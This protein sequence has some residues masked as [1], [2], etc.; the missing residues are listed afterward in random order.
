MTGGWALGNDG[1]DF[2]L[3]QAKIEVPRLPSRALT[4]SHLLARLGGIEQSP[5]AVVVAPAGWGKTLLLSSWLRDQPPVGHVAW[6]SVDPSDADPARF[7]AYVLAALGKACDLSDDHPLAQLRRPLRA[8]VADAD[9]FLAHL[10]NGLESLDVGVT[11]VLDD[12]HLAASADVTRELAFLV[13]HRPHSLNLVLAG[14][15]MLELP[16]ARLRLAGGLLEVGPAELAFSANE[17]ADLF[18]EGG[19]E[20]SAADAGRLHARTEGWP[21]GVRLVE[22]SGQRAGRSEDP[23]GI[24]SGRTSLISD[25]LMSEVLDHMDSGVVEFLMWTSVADSLTEDLAAALTRRPDSSLLLAQMA[26][27]NAFVVSQGTPPV[28]RF[29][30]LFRETLLRKLGR[31]QRGELPRLRRVAADWYAGRGRHVEAA[32]Q[33]AA[34]GEWTEAVETILS[35]WLPLFLHG[36]FASLTRII[37]EVPESMLTEHHELRAVRAVLKQATGEFAPEHNQALVDADAFPAQ[38]PAG[39]HGTAVAIY[40]LER[41]QFVGD[42]DGGRAAAS[43][44]LS[45]RGANPAVKALAQLERGITEFFFGDWDVAEMCV[46]DGLLRARAAGSDYVTLGCLSQLTAVLVAQNKLREGIGPAREALDFAERRGWNE[47]LPLIAG[48]WLVLAWIHF[49]WDEFGDVEACLDRAEVA[50]RSGDAGRTSNR[51]IVE[52]MVLSRRG[53]K[54]AAL[55]LLNAAEEKLGD[56]LQSFV[57]TVYLRAERI[58]ALIALGRNAEAHDEL[59]A[60]GPLEDHQAIV[61]LVWAEWFDSRGE[62]DRAL[63]VLAPAASCEVPGLLD[64]WLQAQVLAAILLRSQ[65]RETEALDMFGTALSMGY[66]QGYRQPFVEFGD[67]AR[68]LLVTYQRINGSHA[69]YVADLLSR[70]TAA[71]DAGVRDP[72]DRGPL[73][74][75]EVDVLRLWGEMMTAPEIAAELYVSV[76]TVKAHLKRIYAKLDATSRRQ[77]VARGRALGL[78]P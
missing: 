4:R 78:L 65:G 67:R 7:W 75:R 13:R 18:A 6:L 47:T 72:Q 60:L 58:R 30:A 51:L 50:L 11:L 69:E 33:L 70:F 73:T 29:H 1:G 52:A 36:E 53:E 61:R 39:S 16:L 10:V 5:L 21:A 55:L 68:D 54:E 19:V 35:G 22:L 25:Y 26:R 9:V 14:R 37:D 41:A 49:C 12:I 3:L 71:P 24:V 48:I 32:E 28:Y 59:L 77:A 27:D 40:T 46:R 56:G 20:L 42:I 23:R 45:D 15:A 31:E 8:T 57:F 43:A 62:I 17:V 64:Q 66:A 34:A 38:L 2:P 76:N 74:A 44:L 63:E